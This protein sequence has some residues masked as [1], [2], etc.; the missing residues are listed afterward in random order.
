MIES[1]LLSQQLNDLVSITQQKTLPESV[2]PLLGSGSNY[3]TSKD[4]SSEIHERESYLC[5]S[6][7]ERTSDLISNSIHTCCAADGKSWI[8]LGCRK[9]IHICSMLHFGSLLSNVW[10]YFGSRS[11]AKGDQNRLWL[12]LFDNTRTLVSAKAFVHIFACRSLYIQTDKHQIR[13]EASYPPYK[14]IIFLEMTLKS[15]RGA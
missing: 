14:V 3:F 7:L 5:S 4:W 1:E 12:E 13:Y 9:S 8:S 11:I 2:S 10:A 6:L 15:R